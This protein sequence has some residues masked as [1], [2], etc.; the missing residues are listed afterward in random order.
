MCSATNILFISLR[1][2]TKWEYY[3]DFIPPLRYLPRETI[4]ELLYYVC[5]GDIWRS[6]YIPVILLNLVISLHS[7]MEILLL[8]RWQFFFSKLVLIASHFISWFIK[9]LIQWLKDLHRRIQKKHPPP[10]TECCLVHSHLFWSLFFFFFLAHIL[11]R[12]VYKAKE[13]RLDV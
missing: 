8:W 13:S 3:N 9:D 5:P 6:W 4:K 10:L 2:K 1:T 12:F 11:C 7:F